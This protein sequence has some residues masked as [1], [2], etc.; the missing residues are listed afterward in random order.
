M[1]DDSLV[2][3]TVEDFVDRLASRSPTPGGGSVAALVGVLAAGLGRMA[4]ALTLGKPKFADVEPNVRAIATRL[5]RADAMLR[6]LVD[7]DAAAYGVLSAALKQNPDDPTRRV[8]V[9]EAAALAGSVPLE[10]V[11]F[12]AQVHSELQRLRGSANPAL[13]SDVDAGIHLTHGAMLAAAANVRANLPLMSSHDAERVERQLDA[14]L[15]PL[16]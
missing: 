4:A 12:I 1:A 10:T 8:K 7:E 3:L 13:R 5:E 9:Q 14:L 2:R 6:R 15:E 11:A 16:R